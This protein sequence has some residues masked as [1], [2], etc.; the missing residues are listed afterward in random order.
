MNALI[1]GGF[2]QKFPYG[3]DW[4]QFS[5]SD[6]KSAAHAIRLFKLHYDF[7]NGTDVVNLMQTISEYKVIS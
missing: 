4:V 2:A 7:L 5:I 1:N 6:D 3:E